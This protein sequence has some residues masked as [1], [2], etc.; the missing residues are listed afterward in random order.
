[1]V[2]SARTKNVGH[3]VDGQPCF[4]IPAQAPTHSGEEA[5]TNV[6]FQ[7]LT[8]LVNEVKA[9]LAQAEEDW[10]EWH[11][12]VWYV[13]KGSTLLKFFQEG[14]SLEEALSLVPGYEPESEA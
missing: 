4:G 3:M 10:D 14:G 11:S 13:E 1:M 8:L 7:Q 2:R 12:N 6:Y 5:Q 9:A